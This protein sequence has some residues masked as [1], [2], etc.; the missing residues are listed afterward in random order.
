MHAHPGQ[1]T[2]LLTIWL[3]VLIALGWWVRANLV[4]GTDLRLF[5]PEPTNAEE[6]FLLQEIGESPGSRLLLLAIRGDE[7]DRLAQISTELADRLSADD[8]NRRSIF[9]LIANGDSE[10]TVI[11]DRLLPYRY[12][13]TDAATRGSFTAE[14][15]RR[16]LTERLRDLSSPAAG[17]IEAWIA[18][19]PTL[20]ALRLAD[21]WLPAQEPQRIQ[22]V[23]FDSSGRTALLVAETRA[24]AFDPTRQAA[25]LASI[26]SSFDAAR[27]Q[28]RARLT[29]S[30]P[31]AF[32]VFMQRHVSTEASSRGVIASIGMIL[33][34]VLAYRDLR[35]VLAGLLPL[36]SAA[37]AGLAIVTLQFGTVHGITLAFG[38]TLLG[39]A[40]DYP[41][42]LFSHRRAGETALATAKRIWRP[43]LTGVA[44]TCI[45]YLAF[46][47][48]G[49][50]GLA[51]LGW[52]TVA[53]LLA[54]GLTTRYLLPRLLPA[55]T[56]VVGMGN[57][58]RRLAAVIER[59]PRAV[60]PTLALSVLA[61]LAIVTSRTSLW[62]NDLS[63]LTPVPAELLQEDAVLR[64]ELGAPDV[65]YLLVDRGRTA[66]AALDRTASRKSRLDAL[67]KHGVVGGY[68][69]AAQYLPSRVVQLRRRNALPDSVALEGALRQASVNLPFTLDA[70]APFVD[71]VRAARQLAPLTVAD[72]SGT[73]LELRVGGMLF[74][75]DGEWIGVTT[76]TRVRDAAA[77]ARGLQD[78]GPDTAFIDLKRASETLVTRQ[79]GHIL[80]SLASAAFALM[81]VMAVTLRRPGRVVRVLLP[82]LITTLVTVAC[83]QLVGISL[84]LFHLVALALAAG[85]G[86]D[87]AV[88]FEHTSLASGEQRQTLHSVLLCA[89]STLLVF[90]LLA[91]SSV[92]VLRSIGLTVAIGVACNFL[93]ALMISRRV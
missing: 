17:S 89:T 45:A 14:S 7:P 40:Q 88:F 91:T 62:E 63:K 25:A 22:G 30:G 78:L 57:G 56:R 75:R 53:G 68:D 59:L 36:A 37:L 87:Y 18:R 16:T 26:Q 60:W 74:E 73:P 80:R 20:E 46:L 27:G 31:G 32:S 49:V 5:M 79:R 72:L 76:F 48:A 44:S 12:L 4:V 71:D 15:L 50:A 10:R 13:L 51:Q 92:P 34:L 86:L 64:R 66:E 9:T 54:A 67:V 77:L 55:E 8:Q 2:I 38:F 35:V 41:I 11:P 24:A 33:L 52:F 29:I 39:V 83:L 58:F 23:W 85:L 65:R 21:A 19:D 42:H 81:L 90:V 84:S 28:S 47:I 93:L 6:R 61:I 70:F 69:N 1:R 43:L 82:A 3:L